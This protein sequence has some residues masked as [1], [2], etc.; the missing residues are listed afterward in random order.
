MEEVDLWE[1][2]QWEDDLLDQE[3]EEVSLVHEKIQEEVV[4]K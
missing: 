3:E 2:R 1:G 4:V